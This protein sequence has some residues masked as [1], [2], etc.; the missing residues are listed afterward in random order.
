MIQH[1][2][3]IGMLPYSSLNTIIKD[4]TSLPIKSFGLMIEVIV[5]G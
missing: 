3:G 5:G 4:Y 1:I 2:D